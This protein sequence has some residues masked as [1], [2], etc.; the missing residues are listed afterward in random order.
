MM[1]HK[2][3]RILTAA[4]ALVCLL[5]LA[6]CSSTP[7]APD[8]A[9]IT[10]DLNCSEET[11]VDGGMTVT[12]LTIT[13][14]QT[15]PEDKI[16]LV[17]VE[18]TAA[19][20]AAEYTNSA[21]LTYGLYNDGWMLDSIEE[22]GKGDFVSTLELD[23]DSVEAYLE[24][25]YRKDYTLR[26]MST[27]GTTAMYVFDHILESDVV[28]IHD[29]IVLTYR[30]TENGWSSAPVTTTNPDPE[31]HW[32]MSGEWEGEINGEKFWLKFHEVS[33]THQ[34]VVAE[35]NFGDTVVSDGWTTMT[36]ENQD[37][38]DEELESWVLVPEGSSWGPVEIHPFGARY[39]DA[40]E[41][42]GLIAKSEDNHCWLT[43]K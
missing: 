6:G 29:P 32:L 38:W 21:L 9:A 35:Y 7:D 10:A 2:F 19:S 30:A 1:K 43:R 33:D 13:K 3:F 24:Q 31:L 5:A 22:D 34:A 28:I 20:D 42:S 18:Y 14:R 27:T 12:G 36:I 25:M 39:T 37:F 16:D 26:D 23:P 17:W 41:G 8:E 15:T 4:L 11:I 40:G